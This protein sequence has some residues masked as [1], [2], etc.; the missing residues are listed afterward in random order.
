MTGGDREVTGEVTGVTG[1]RF[2]SRS[3]NHSMFVISFHTI[4]YTPTF[5]SLA[6]I[7]FGSLAA[8]LTILPVFYCIP[9]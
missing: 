4:I 5:G 1:D 7:P 2:V 8:K 3:I 9:Y 6:A